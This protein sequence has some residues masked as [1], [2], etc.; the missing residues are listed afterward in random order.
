MKDY[1]SKFRGKSLTELHK[2]KL[3]EQKKSNG[4]LNQREEFDRVR[5]M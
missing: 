4:T 2:E 5:D 1:D 3:K